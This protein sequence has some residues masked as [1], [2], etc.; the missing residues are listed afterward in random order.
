MDKD[1][2]IGKQALIEQ[3]K[4]K[5]RQKRLA[6]F[7]L[8]DSEPLLLGDEPIFRNGKLV[9]I[10][11]SGNFG[12]SIGK[13]VGLGYIENESGVNIEFLQTGDFEIQIGLKKYAVDV[14]FK[15]AYDPKNEKV[16]M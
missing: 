5:V 10:I 16:K 2:F 15:P 11:T 8:R 12:H 6:V 14:Q 3:K 13:S 4:N 7:I 1:T 9:G